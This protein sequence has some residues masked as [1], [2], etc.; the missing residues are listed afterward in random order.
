MTDYD[1]PMSQN[2]MTKGFEGMINRPQIKLKQ[3][4]QWETLTYTSVTIHIND[5]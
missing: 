3:N 5:N 1:L 4:F 2:Y